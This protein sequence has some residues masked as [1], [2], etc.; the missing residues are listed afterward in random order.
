MGI[1]FENLV[2]VS[3]GIEMTFENGYEY[4]YSDTH[5]MPIPNF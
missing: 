4:V 3:V 2:S 1:D 5:P